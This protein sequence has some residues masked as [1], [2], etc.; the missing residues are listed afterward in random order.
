[1]AHEAICVTSRPRSD[2]QPAIQPLRCSA[3]RF[4][5]REERFMSNPWLPIDQ[6][7]SFSEWGNRYDPLAARRQAARGAS[8]AGH[9]TIAA[10]PSPNRALPTMRLGF[11]V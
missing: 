8:A 4:G 7:R 5:T 2:S 6:L 10:A 1:M 11:Q 9:A 3:I